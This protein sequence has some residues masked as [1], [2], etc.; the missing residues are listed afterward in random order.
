MVT[1][2]LA[3]A[4]VTG[5]VLIAVMYEAQRRQLAARGFAVDAFFPPVSILK[6]LKGVDPAL[7]DNLES[8]F[9]LDFPEYEILFGVEDPEDPA[10]AVARRVMARHPLQRARL[11]FAGEVVGFNPKVN[12]LAGIL[13]HARHELLLISD[14]NVAVDPQMLGHMVE[15]ISDGNVG[16]VTSFIRGVGGRGLGG[17][18]ESLQ[19]NTFVM[20]GVAAVSGPLDQVCAVG[21]SML[22]RRA[23]LDR[24]GGFSELGQ[25]LAEDQVCA[26]KIRE[27]GRKVVVCPH[28][29]D[30]VLGRISMRGFAGRHLRWARIRRHISLPGYFGE[31]LTNPLALAASLFAVAPGAGSAALAATAFVIVCATSVA[32]ERRLGVRR[33]LFLYPM[34]VLVRALAV[35]AMWPVP[36]VSSSVSWR[37]R[38]FRIT[39]RTRLVPDSE[40]EVGNVSGLHT[41]EAAA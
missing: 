24:L 17:A 38:R 19:L 7:E 1:W 2:F 30:N 10:V 28:P 6:P 35:A 34:L 36:L 26:E 37:G 16:L 29:I 4:T 9:H 3:A 20:G 22:L 11:V 5:L 14:S 25:F 12:N 41:E 40:E 27:L 39:E 18:L 33:S 32:A 13:P 21:K 31:L 23:D 8:F 15:K